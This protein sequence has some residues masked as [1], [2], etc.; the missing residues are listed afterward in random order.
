MGAVRATAVP[1]RQERR[2]KFSAHFSSLAARPSPGQSLGWDISLTNW[3]RGGADSTI[4]PM[5]NWSSFASSC[6]TGLK[7]GRFRA[8]VERAGPLGGAPAWPREHDINATIERALPSAHRKRPSGP[9]P[10][11]KTLWRSST[12]E[13][14]ELDIDHPRPV[15]ATRGLPGLWFG[16]PMTHEVWWTVTA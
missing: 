7:P 16:R 14:F 12:A 9:R 1:H 8:R 13:P 4:A 11:R 10:L 5:L 15:A 6:V 3:S 2:A